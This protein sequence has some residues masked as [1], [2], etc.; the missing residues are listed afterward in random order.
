VC[1]TVMMLLLLPSLYSRGRCC[2]G[3]SDGSCVLDDEDD[4]DV[5]VDVGACV[6]VGV[7]SVGDGDSICVFLLMVR[8]HFLPFTYSIGVIFLVVAI[9]VAAVVVAIAASLSLLLSLLFSLLYATVVIRLRSISEGVK[10]RND[11]D[12]RH[13]DVI[14]L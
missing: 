8:R 11:D 1:M 2:V 6:S 7:G 9:V 14:L 3:G 12:G 5:V 4:D 10:S 13:V